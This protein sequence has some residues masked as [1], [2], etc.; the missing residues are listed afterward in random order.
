MQDESKMEL[1]ERQLTTFVARKA[2]AINVDLRRAFSGLKYATAWL[3]R[4]GSIHI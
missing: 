2:N 4:Y 1:N 3:L